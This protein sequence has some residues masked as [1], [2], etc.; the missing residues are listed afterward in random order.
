[1]EKNDIKNLKPEKVFK[2]FLDIC[3]IPHGSGNLDGIVNYLVNFAKERQ[4]RYITDDAKNVIMYKDG[5]SSSA[6]NH[7]GENFEPVILQAHTDMVAVKTIDSKKDLTK[8]AIEPYV[9][10]NFLKARDTSLG[11][12]DGIGVALILAILDDNTGS[13]PPIEALFT[14]EEET[15]MNG[16]I[17]IDGKLF[18]GKKLVNIDSENEEELTVSCCGGSHLESTFPICREERSNQAI[19]SVKISN[20][21]GGHS[22][23][24]IHKGRANAITEIA[25]T[26]KEMLDNNIDFSLIK[27]EGGQFENVIC[28]ETISDICVNLNDEEKFLSIIKRIN[29]D[30]KVEYRLSDKD[31]SLSAVKKEGSDT[32]PFTKESTKKLIDTIFKLPQG[33]IEISQEFANLPWTSLNHGVIH[34]E[35]K[36]VNLVTF[37][38]SND[39]IKRIKLVKKCRSIIEDGGGEL[40]VSGEYPA[41]QYKKDSKLKDDMVHLYKEL[42]G[43]DM[44]VIATHGGLE[45]GL[46]MEKIPGLEAVSIGPTIENVHSV[47]ERL[48]IDS[49]EKTYGFLKTFLQRQC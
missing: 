7:K 27:V 14:S 39:D 49:V 25:Y 20:L 47:D 2:F 9:D 44:K 40:K 24:E 1:L 22:G 42:N 23:M 34:T 21:L 38:R 36:E 17:A 35:D 41:W 19:Y 43:K 45:C 46:L 33:L 37:V 6:T 26:L 16:A 4:L 29:D 28:Q 8:D 32:M 5:T 30:L 11:A 13:Y 10:G 31:I 18:N 3:D 12:D 48:H 15:G